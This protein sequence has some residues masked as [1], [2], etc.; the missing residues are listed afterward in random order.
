MHIE[1]T[2]L[3]IKLVK[4]YRTWMPHTYGGFLKKDG[5][6]KPLREVLK[7]RRKRY[8]NPFPVWSCDLIAYE[9]LKLGFVYKSNNSSGTWICT[10]VSYLNKP[11]SVLRNVNGGLIKGFYIP[12]TELIE[13]PICTQLTITTNDR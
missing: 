9:P 3:K 1:A 13:F 7:L 12:P 11:R 4:S 5:T 10:S 2:N 8:R 6:F